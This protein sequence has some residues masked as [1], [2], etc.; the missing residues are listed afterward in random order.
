MF[1]EFFRKKSEDA[2]RLAADTATA[3]RPKGANTTPD[4]CKRAVGMFPDVD[5]RTQDLKDTYSLKFHHL[6]IS[7]E[8]A[9]RTGCLKITSSRARSRSAILLYR[10]R[11]VGAVYGRKQM[12]GQYLH[13]DAHKCALSDLASPGNVLDAYELP[14]EL[15]L[16][17]ASLFYGETLDTSSEHNPET[18]FD[19][20]VSS[21]MRSGLPGTVVV[22]TMNQETMCVIYIAKGRVVGVFSATEGWT[23][24]S[25]DTVKR[26]MRGGNCRVHA[27]ILPM[28]DLRSIGFSLTG[29]GD[30]G[31]RIDASPYQD[32]SPGPSA[33]V[34][35][36]S[37]DAVAQAVR[38]HRETGQHQ[39]A[40][41]RDYARV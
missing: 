15:V 17:A 26:F 13:E 3:H 2:L 11:V 12:R 20:A 39:I 31:A 18:A 23:R 9:E 16:A 40:G 25:A 27:S 37:R 36:P 29:L 38:Q 22:N 41:V 34:R 19:Y 30:K 28:D 14:E 1:R 24:A 7:L 5:T 21:L 35:T 33:V 10:G 8:G 6:L 32:F 4:A